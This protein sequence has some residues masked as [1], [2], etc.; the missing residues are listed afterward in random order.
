MSINASYNNILTLTKPDH[1]GTRTSGYTLQRFL[2]DALHPYT[3]HL[4][5]SLAI[6]E[7]APVDSKMKCLECRRRIRL[8]RAEDVRQFLFGEEVDACFVASGVQ[9]RPENL[10]VG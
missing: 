2:E 9:I 1:L 8:C 7:Q 10:L 6:H 5:L 3:V 4:Q